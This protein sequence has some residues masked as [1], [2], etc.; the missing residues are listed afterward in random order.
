MTAPGP[1][2]KVTQVAATQGRDASGTVGP[3]WNV[4]YQLA[5]GASGQIFVPKTAADMD[6]VKAAVAADAATL[7]A[8]S[9]LT[10]G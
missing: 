1:D 9:N 2:W 4:T 8:I 5:G 10:S 3:G 7:H 6:A